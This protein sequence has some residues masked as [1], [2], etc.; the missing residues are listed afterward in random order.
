MFLQ[1]TINGRTMVIYSEPSKPFI[2]MTNHGQRSA[3]E[4]KLLKK[5]RAFDRPIIPWPAFANAL[6][7]HYL[8]ETKQD[9]LK[10]LRILSYRYSLPD[11][12]QALHDLSSP[13]LTL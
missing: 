9:P 11:F 8:Q 6:Q 3:T 12:L 7:L 2:V 1:L 13:P 10:P 5:N 4:G